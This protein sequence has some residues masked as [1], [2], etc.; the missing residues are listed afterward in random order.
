MSLSFTVLLFV[1][2]SLHAEN[3][4]F[5]LIV[6]CISSLAA[7]MRHQKA[8]YSFLQG[9]VNGVSSGEDMDTYEAVMAGRKSKFES[10]IR[11][12]NLKSAVLTHKKPTYL[13]EGVHVS[14]VLERKG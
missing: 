14:S 4:E 1:F 3:T 5:Q 11:N 8:R 10:C 9:G 2:D 13:L 12:V 7:L 6:P